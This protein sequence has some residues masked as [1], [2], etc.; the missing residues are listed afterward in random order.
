[1]G[2]P[3]VGVFYGGDYNAPAVAPSRLIAWP[4]ARSFCVVYGGSAVVVRADD[5]QDT[6][7]IDTYPV[8]QMFVV[9]ER[10]MVVFANFTNLTAYSA[11]GL[12]WRSQRLALDEVRVEGIG[13][14]ALTVY[15]FFGASSDRFS[16]DLATGEPSGQPFQP[17]D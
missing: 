10:G 8:T 4:D 7:E 15:G 12:L 3:W 17:P 11:D 5:P 6:Y 14:D 1:V 9:A 2:D 13:G 16:V